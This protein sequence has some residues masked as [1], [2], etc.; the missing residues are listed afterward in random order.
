A[1]KADHEA[2][3]AYVRRPVGKTSAPLYSYFALVADDPSVQIVSNAQTWY[4]KD[5]LKDT[6][7]KDWPVLSAA[8]P[9]KAGGRGGADYYTDVPAGDIAIK[10]VSDLYLY[11]NTVRAVAITGADVKEWLEM[12]SGIFKTIEPGKPDQPLI[13][14]SFPSYNFDVID[15]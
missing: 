13:D 12:S 2:T 10:N 1:A 11:P 3:L 14:T 5:M 8:A 15:G 7:W 6:Q 9:F 4:I